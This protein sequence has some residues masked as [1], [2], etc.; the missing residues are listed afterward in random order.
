MFHSLEW[1]HST[2]IANWGSAGLLASVDLIGE[3]ILS[4]REKFAA[5]LTVAS[6]K[7]WV[8]QTQRRRCLDLSGLGELA[9]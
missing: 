2:T 6:K 9:G 3:T 4:E 5:S 7:R 1:S 8:D